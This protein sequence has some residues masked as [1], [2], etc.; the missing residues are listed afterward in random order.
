MKQWHVFQTVRLKCGPFG[1]CCCCCCCFSPCLFS[2]NC[3]CC[4]S[5]S[6]GQKGLLPRKLKDFKLIKHFM[7]FTSQ[8][9]EQ[10]TS[11]RWLASCQSGSV[12]ISLTFG[13]WLV[14]ISHPAR[15]PGDRSHQNHFALLIKRHVL[16][17]RILYIPLWT[18]G[19]PFE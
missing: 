13:R 19:E 2:L 12:K 18:S 17:L 10:K 15:L 9:R 6:E 16:V 8:Q 4:S 11:G 1:R 3:K 14:V 7:G 5:N